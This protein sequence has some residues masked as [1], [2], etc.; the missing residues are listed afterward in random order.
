MVLAM[1]IWD[2]VLYSLLAYS[3]YHLIRDILSDIFGIH[4]PLIDIFHRE[5]ASAKW[6]GKWCKWHTFPIEIFY[7]IV[8]IYL[9][10]TQ[11]F[12]WLGGIMIVLMIPIALQY[13]NIVIK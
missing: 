11:Q 2:I 9:L 6:C 8:S 7:I 4:H 1:K 12:G 10:K 3:C 5:S 13:F